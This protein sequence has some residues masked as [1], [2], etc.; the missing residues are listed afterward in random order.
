MLLSLKIENEHTANYQFLK[1]KKKG[2]KGT[3]AKN[4]NRTQTYLWEIK[5][6]K[7]G[8]EK[9]Q[10]RQSVKFFLKKNLIEC[11]Y[12]TS[13]YIIYIKY[14]LWIEDSKAN[15]IY[16]DIQF[17]EELIKFIYLCLKCFNTKLILITHT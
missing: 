3:F 1:L 9:C 13:I 7:K 2:T 17:I 4:E 10:K 15:V 8:G 5:L 16:W 6:H 12:V 11:N 14:I